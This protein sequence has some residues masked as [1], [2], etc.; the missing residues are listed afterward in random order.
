[1][2]FL[3]IFKNGDSAMFWVRISQFLAISSRVIS[4]ENFKPKIISS[5]VLPTAPKLAIVNIR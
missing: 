1:M 5:L 3:P 4:A 2:F